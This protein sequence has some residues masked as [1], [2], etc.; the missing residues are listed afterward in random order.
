M[1]SRTPGSV[2]ASVSCQHSRRVDQVSVPGPAREAVRLSKHLFQALQDQVRPRPAVRRYGPGHGGV[3]GHRAGPEPFHRCIQD[4]KI[5]FG[6]QAFPLRRPGGRGGVSGQRKGVRIQQTGRP[7]GRDR[8]DL[9]RAASVPRPPWRP[10]R[11]GCR[12]GTAE[13]RRQQRAAPACR[14]FSP[15]PRRR[16]IPGSPNRVKCSKVSYAE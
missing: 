12:T 3:I 10:S 9:R 15:E 14:W 5:Q 8:A 7:A 16:R 6:W 4:R 11:P 2:L 13:A 1:A